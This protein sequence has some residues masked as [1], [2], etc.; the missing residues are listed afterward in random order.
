MVN[1]K[2]RESIEIQWK[3]SNS[4]K[5]KKKKLVGVD[6]LLN[7]TIFFSSLGFKDFFLGFQDFED[8]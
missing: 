7:T 6:G 8:L 4:E 3:K 5:A 2:S 1:Q